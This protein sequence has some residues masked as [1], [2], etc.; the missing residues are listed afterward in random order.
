MEF[1]NSL[2]L[3]YTGV[4][5]LR[6]ALGGSQ[7]ASDQQL[8]GTV[9]V[10]LQD[11]QWAMTVVKPSAMRE[12]AIDVPKVQ[13]LPASLCWFLLTVFAK[14]IFD[15]KLTISQPFPVIIQ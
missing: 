7:Q 4:H 6:R 5:A 2:N 9:T 15:V 3:F 8:I 1:L 14:N 13:I 10:S 12:V 11:L